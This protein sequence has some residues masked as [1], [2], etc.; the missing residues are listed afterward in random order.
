MQV[1][2]AKLM[3]ASHCHLCI[4]VLFLEADGPNVVSIVFEVPQA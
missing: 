3:Y 2:H 1:L 4:N